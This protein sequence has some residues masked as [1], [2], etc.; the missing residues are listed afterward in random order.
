MELAFTNFFSFILNNFINPIYNAFVSS[1]LFNS[2]FTF[3]ERLLSAI[4][5]LWN[6]DNTLDLSNDL[7]L[8]VFV[9]FLGVLL[10]YFI[11]KITISMF[12]LIFNTI[13][14]AI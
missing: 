6:N 5:K 2:L 3:I 11:F 10:L 4:F 9:D 13:R 7:L 8:K 12:N 14:K 1:N